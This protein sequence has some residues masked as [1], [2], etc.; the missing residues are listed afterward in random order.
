MRRSWTVQKFGGTS[1]ADADCFSQVADILCEQRRQRDDENLGAVVSAMGG[2]TDA[3]LRVASRAEA[4]ASAASDELERLGDRYSAASKT[5]LAGDSHVRILDAWST[6]A[7]ALRELFASRAES[8]RAPGL[9]HALTA[10]Y[11]EL[12]SARLLAAVL[13]ER[14][15][16]PEGGVWVDAREVLV[17]RQG[18]MGPQVLWDRSQRNF[19][20]L[21]GDFSGI[22]VITGFIAADEGGE[23]TTLGR[24]GSDYSAAIF[25]RLA[26]ARELTIWT[27]VDG[28]LSGDPRR[29]PEAHVIRNL[30]YNEAMELAYF[31]AKVLHP[32]TMGPVVDR[33]IPVRIKNT[34]APQ[35]RGSKITAQSLADAGI[36]G[37]T[38]VEDVAVINVEGSGMIG[39]PGTADRLFAALRSADVSVTLI[40]QASSEHSICLAVPRS[41][42]ERAQ[43]VISEAFVD[44]LRSGQI[45]RVDATDEQSIVAVVGDNMA[46]LPGVAAK[47]FGTLGSAGINV[48]AIAQGSSERNISAVV[49]FERRNPGAAGRALGLLSVG[50]DAIH[51]AVGAG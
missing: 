4:D 51:W 20:R 18:E 49:R 27:D 10:S 24:N 22:A 50:K 45:Q 29:I 47:F 43:R 14:L 7:A 36:K 25:A 38:A 2:M 42:A 48:R 34:F 33:E 28:V 11:G 1:L 12:W 39:V 40:S 26:A 23:P 30:S 31:G 19:D 17:V 13:H 21:L 32:Q 9:S 3:L 37:I 41:L 8:Q 44:E 5:L 15:G 46:G 6:D 16:T 35:H